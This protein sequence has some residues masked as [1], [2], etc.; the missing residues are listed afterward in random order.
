MPERERDD[1]D[2]EDIFDSSLFTLFSIPPIGFAPDP[3]DGYYTYNPPEGSTGDQG[4][5]DKIR[6]VRLKIP[7]P[8]SKFYTTLQA[9]LVWPSAIYLA[10]LICRRIIDVKGKNV[11][12]LG[13]AA[14]LPGVVSFLNDARKVVSTDYPIDEVLDVLRGNFS[15]AERS[16]VFDLEQT[17]AQNA[18]SEQSD[19]EGDKEL[20]KWEVMGH[21]W[22]EN[23]SPLLALIPTT[24]ESPKPKKFDTILAADVLWTT[25]SH[26]ILLD[27]ITSLLAENGIAHITAG[28]HTGRGPVERFLVSAKE[29]GF[30]VDYKGEVRLRGDGKWDEYDESLA[31][32]GEEERGVVVWFTLTL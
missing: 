12:E 26:S 22:G 25:S 27:S 5:R 1:E 28:L 21:C 29:R 11:I 30:T 8:P 3:K 2:L 14:G 9:Q 16:L 17:A 13:S 23:T 4:S 7:E 15:R 20:K 10:D 31:K 18:R 32:K 6:S 19:E 24:T